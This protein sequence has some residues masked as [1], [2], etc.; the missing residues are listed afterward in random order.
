[1]R[2]YFFYDYPSYILRIKERQRR[3]DTE[4]S[5]CRRCAPVRIDDQPRRSVTEILLIAWT[6]EESPATRQSRV[7]ERTLRARSR[8]PSRDKKTAP[9]KGADFLVAATDLIDYARTH[10]PILLG[11]HV[12]VSRKQIPRPVH[13]IH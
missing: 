2:F 4:K 11:T 5:D 6:A 10:L 12:T 13:R 1:M 3:S 9:M 8:C 7:Y